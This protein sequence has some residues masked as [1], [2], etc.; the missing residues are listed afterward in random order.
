LLTG[1]LEEKTIIESV[2]NKLKNKKKV[3]ITP[4]MFSLEEIG[5]VLSKARLLIAPSTSV[6]H[7]AS[8]FN[9]PIVNLIPKKRD[10]YEWRPWMKKE[11]YRVLFSSKTKFNP[12]VPAEFANEGLLEITPEEVIKTAETLLKKKMQR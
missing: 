6:V 11:D 1:T 5:V 8:S 12:N 3:K 4:G 9:V 7:I 10:L 2:Y